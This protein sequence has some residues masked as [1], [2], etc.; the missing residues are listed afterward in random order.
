MKKNVDSQKVKLEDQ[1]DKRNEIIQKLEAARLLAGERYSLR[2]LSPSP[3]THKKKC[4]LEQCTDVFNCGHE[5]RHPGEV[6]KRRLDQDIIK[7][8]KV[9]YEAEE[10]LKRRES[11]IEPVQK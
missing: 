11:A 5:K 2:K 9:V 7:Q 10:E 6:N 4:T 1:K 3:G 8:E